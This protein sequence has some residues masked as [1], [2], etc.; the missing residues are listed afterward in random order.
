MIRSFDLFVSNMS[1]T[2]GSGFN[3]T[4]DVDHRSW[5][6]VAS[7]LSLLYSLLCLAARAVSKW[8]FLW[9]DDIIL[10]AAYISGLAHWGILFR[11]LANGL[12]V[13]ESVLSSSAIQYASR[14]STHLYHRNSSELVVVLARYS[15]STTPNICLI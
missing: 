3:T 12:A 14:V 4:T 15:E 6:W 7:F 11:A 1:G 2:I 5:V 8:D 13:S 10:A 9:F